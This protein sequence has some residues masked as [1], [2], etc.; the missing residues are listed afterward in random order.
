MK[1]FWLFRAWHL[2][3]CEKHSVCNT[4]VNRKAMAVHFAVCMGADK[5]ITLMQV[6]LNTK[7]TLKIENGAIW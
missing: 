7:L 3:I 1:V 5:H 4:R 6:R 2:F